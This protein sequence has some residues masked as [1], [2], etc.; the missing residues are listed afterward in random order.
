MKSFLVAAIVLLA[1]SAQAQTFTYDFSNLSPDDVAHL[2][3]LLGREQSEAAAAF[4]A[5]K[6]LSERMQKQITAKDEAAKDTKPTDKKD[7]PPTT[8]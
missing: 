2:G 5:A 8:P 6:D 3:R 7:D 1:G 4:N